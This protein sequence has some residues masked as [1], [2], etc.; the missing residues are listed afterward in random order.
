M[1]DSPPLDPAAVAAPLRLLCVNS[2]AA[3]RIDVGDRTVMSAI[4]KRAMRGAVRVGNL[5][6]EGDEQADPTVH[7]GVDKAVYA[8]PSEHYPFWDAAR[9]DA[10]IAQASLLDETLAYGA[11][12]ENLT[13][14]GLLEREVYVGDR[15]VF[16]DCELVVSEPRQPCF[17]FVAVMGFKHAAKA[18][19]QAENCGFYLRVSRPG[20]IEAGQAFTLLPGARELRIDLAFRRKMSRREV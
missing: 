3:R 12:G 19:A 13:L 7:G 14:A 8:Y 9:R 5:G 20:L 10:G 1:Q 6:L 17:K 4:T 11:L 15:L 16:P 2:A 18:M